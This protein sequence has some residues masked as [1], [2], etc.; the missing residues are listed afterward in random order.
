MGT[1]D[2]MGNEIFLKNE[3]WNEDFQGLGVL[4]NEDFHKRRKGDGYF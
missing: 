1:K 4:K 2:C 3:R